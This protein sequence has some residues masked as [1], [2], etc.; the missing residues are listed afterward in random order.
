M[1]RSIIT[2]KMIRFTA[3]YGVRYGVSVMVCAGGIPVCVSCTVAYRRIDPPVKQRI[4]GKSSKTVYIKVQ[5][6][7]LKVGSMETKSLTYLITPTP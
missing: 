5:C 1:T 3:L 4:G 6:I 7:M 2:T